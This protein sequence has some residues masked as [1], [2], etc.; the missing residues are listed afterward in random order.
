MKTETVSL[1]DRGTLTLPAHFRKALGLSNKQ[2]F[3]LSVN[4]HGEIVLTPATLTPTE[5]YDE[6]RLR[7][8]EACD[9]ELGEVLKQKK[10]AL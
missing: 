9:L 2:Q 3:I 6:A 4:M 5:I 1:T 10:L 8:F 7:E